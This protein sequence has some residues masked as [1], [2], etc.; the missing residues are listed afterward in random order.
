MVVGGRGGGA[1]VLGMGGLG[2]EVKGKEKEVGG[3]RGLWLGVGDEEGGRFFFIKCG[4]HINLSY[5]AMTRRQVT[6]KAFT[7]WPHRHSNGQT[8]LTVH[9]G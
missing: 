9:P 7:W 4:T 2:R 8:S 1:V 3:G 5:V 6:N